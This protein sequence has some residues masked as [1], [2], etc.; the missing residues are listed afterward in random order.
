MTL[1]RFTLPVGLILALAL[2][3]ATPAMAQ[4]AVR[5]ETVYTMSGPP[6]EDGIVVIENGK[7]SALGRA[8]QIR[9]PDGYRTLTAAVVTPGLIDAH[10]TVGLTGIL[11]IEHDQDQLESASPVQPE[12]R[13]IDAYNP[14]EELLDWVRSFGVTTVH[15]GHGP[16][17]LISGQTM[18]VKTLSN[19][20]EKSLLVETRAVACTLSTL[21]EKESGSP[22]TRGKMMAMLRSELIKAQEYQAKHERA[23]A[24]TGD[25]AASP[26]ARDLRLETLSRVLKGELPLMITADRAQDIASALRLAREFNLKLWLDSAAEAYL[27]LDDIKAAGV[28][29]LVHP[30]MQR[31]YDD[32]ENQ[33]FTTAARLSAAGIPI[34]LQSGFEAYVPKVRVVLF[35]AALAAAHGL[36]KEKALAAMTIDAARILGVADRVGSL[37]VG[38]DGDIAL[39]DG[40]PLEYT[41]HCTGVVINGQVASETVR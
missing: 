9:V 40:D 20:V 15:T 25:A 29:V 32:R 2:S 8:D 33:S 21:A 34:A 14:R 6:I 36:P 11:N 18:V 16:G 35:E 30:A 10:A 17:E 13:A 3:R 5:G 31:A 1:L 38:K 27:L 39:Y 37:E 28:P 7:I 41:T 4:V 12:L 19:S 23:A 24:A 26:P 22:G